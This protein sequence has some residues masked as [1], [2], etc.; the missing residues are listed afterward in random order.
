M[1]HAFKPRLEADSQPLH[2]LIEKKIEIDPNLLLNGKPYSRGGKNNTHFERVS[3]QANR[4]FCSTSN[5]GFYK[6]PQERPQS[7]QQSRSKIAINTSLSK[8][9]EDLV[10]RPQTSKGQR[11]VVYSREARKKSLGDEQQ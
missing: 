8:K 3:K 5:D 7:K 1:G 6:K 4:E 11:N 10:E 9:K 2:H